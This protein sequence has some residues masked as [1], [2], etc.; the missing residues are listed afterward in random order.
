MTS[1]SSGQNEIQEKQKQENKTII[2]GIS[3]VFDG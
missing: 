3:V 1:N 2:M